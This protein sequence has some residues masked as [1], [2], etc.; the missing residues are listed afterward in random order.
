MIKK[1]L[2][3]RELPPDELQA[4]EYAAEIRDRSFMKNSHYIRQAFLMYLADPK[5]KKP[6]LK[7]FAAEY[8]VKV[9]TLRRIKKHP[10]FQREFRAYI[11]HIIGND[12]DIRRA[13]QE[14]VKAM[15]RGEAWAV[16]KI[17][18][19]TGVME[20]VSKKEVSP[21]GFDEIW[22]EIKK[23]GRRKRVEVVDAEFE[24]IK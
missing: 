1:D 19:D 9:Q 20:H 21:K 16:K 11:R 22:D 4:I 18:E 2:A 15:K 6:D 5:L 10:S 12:D 17:L 13:Y 8:N 14:L 24:E 3:I 7:K 23:E